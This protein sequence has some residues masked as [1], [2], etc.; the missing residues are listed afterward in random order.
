MT[1]IGF[2]ASHEQVSPRQLLVDVQHAERAGFDM[3]MC[4]DHFSPWSTRQGHSGYTWSWLGAALA[5]TSLSLGCVS[6]PGQRYHP[7]VHAQRIA[8]LGQMFPGRFWVALGSGEASNE[9]ITGDGWPRKE[10]RTQRLE[11]CVDVIRRMLAGEEVSHD[12]LVTVD[13]ARLWDLPDPV[14]LLVGP[15]VSVESAARVAAWADGLVTV[16]QPIETLRDVLSAYRDAGGRGRTALQVHLSWATTE[17][18]ALGVAHDQWAG[19]VYGP[20]VSWDL[21]TV[22]A[23]DVLWGQVDPDAVRDAVRV[24]ADLA[25]H[26]EWLAEYAELGFDDLYLHHVG[27]QQDAFIEAFGKHVLPILSTGS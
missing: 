26:R 2:H 3:A 19:N 14:P 9:H 18:E 12:G 25:Q 16:N 4:S 24:S 1:R 15:A 23:F 7:A 21:E 8:T 17:A 10:L 13:R 22:E 6:A 11:E 20:P 27:Q 5:T